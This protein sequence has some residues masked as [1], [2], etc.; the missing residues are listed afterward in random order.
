MVAMHD[1]VF[2]GGTVVDGTGAPARQADVAIEG[3][4]I[5]AVDA[6]I[7]GSTHR[8]I[9]A[10]GLLVAPGFVDIHTH[11]DGQMTWDG[12][13]APSALHGVTTAV[14]GN[15]GV[16]FAPVRPGWQDWLIGLMEGVEDIP[17]IA[18]SEGLDWSWETFGEFLDVA[19]RR[20]RAM[21]VGVLIAHGPVRAYVMGERGAYNGAATAEDIDAMASIVRD[22][23]VAGALG[24]STSRTTIHK[25]VNGEPVPGTWATWDELAG[26]TDV[27]ASLGTGVFELATAGSSGEDLSAP[28]KEIAWIRQMA[29][30]I[31]RPISFGTA[32]A[33]NAPDLWRLMYDGA[34]A[35]AAE[36]FSIHPQVLGRAQ[37]VLIGHQTLHPFQYRPTYVELNQLPFADK[38]ARLRDPE[39][40]TRIL[41]EE[42]MAPPAS[43]AMASL[44]SYPP[45]RLFPI[46][47]PPDYEPSPDKSVAAIAAR[48][49][50]PAIEVL[51]DL[52]L[53]RD[54]QELLMYVLM[55]F[56]GGDLSA[57]REMLVNSQSILGLSDGGAHYA[58]ICDASAPTY[59]LTHWVRDR[60]RGERLPLEFVISK[61]TSLPAAVF[62]LG[63]RGTLAPGMRADINL[64]DL[65]ALSLEAPTMVHDLPSGAGRLTQGAHGYVAT[66]VAGQ[67]VRENDVDTGERPGRLVRGARSGPG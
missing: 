60:T 32:Q 9:D 1:V 47:D 13:L 29:R 4:I 15:C 39:I 31:G 20:P 30:R 53:E 63:D 19:A 62:G 45:E 26:I 17:G 6:S 57:V 61:Q 64:I 14:C 40:K 43:D 54:G 3:G 59:M 28:E 36:G 11:Y 27:L 35:S 37:S 50:R 2:R 42:P 51:Y 8:T 22:A 10:G 65:D 44:Y 49:G 67:A 41:A 55:N 34:L 52:M 18:L 12:L 38:M 5:T 33:D 46:G 21:D 56:A 58:H 48:S 66:F 23:I 25:A 7:T 24:F 16:G